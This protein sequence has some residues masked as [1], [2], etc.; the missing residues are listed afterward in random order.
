MDIA[1]FSANANQLRYVF[2]KG[3]GPGRAFFFIIAALIMISL[4]L[5]VS[6]VT[7]SIVICYRTDKCFTWWA[8]VVFEKRITFVFHTYKFFSSNSRKLP[9]SMRI[10]PII[11]IHFLKIY[12]TGWRC[13][14]ST[15]KHQIYSL[16][17]T[18]TENSVQIW[19]L[20]YSGYFSDNSCERIYSCFRRFGNGRCNSYITTLQSSQTKKFD[21]FYCI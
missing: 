16:R 4:V 10:K 8:S 14:S 12:S 11:T 7:L 2:E 17:A 6:R 21:V 5:Q 20:C 3:A 13:D 9:N 1:L 15:S 19:K 18:S